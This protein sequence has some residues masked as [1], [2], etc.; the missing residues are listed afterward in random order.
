[1]EDT[2][3]VRFWRRWGGRIL[4]SD[5]GRAEVEAILDDFMARDLQFEDYKRVE[6]IKNTNNI[7]YP[8]L[9]VLKKAA[10]RLGEDRVVVDAVLV[11]GGMSKFYMVTDRLK[12]FF[13]FDPIVA[14]DPDQAVARGA[15][16]YHYYL[17]KYEELQDDMRTVQNAPSSIIG[18]EWGRNILNDSL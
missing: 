7:I 13:G 1:M 8:I 9:D 15:A 10:E 4:G 14:L 18:I 17:H 5:P 6:R 16:V 12:E 11:N 3:G 2:D